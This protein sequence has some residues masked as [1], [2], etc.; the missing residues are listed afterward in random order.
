MSIFYSQSSCRLS[1]KAAE[2]Y[3]SVTN[4]Q[5]PIQTSSN[6]QHRPHPAPHHP[7]HDQNDPGRQ[8]LSITKPGV[9][10]L[11]HIMS[12]LF[13]CVM[14]ADC[15]RINL[16]H[17]QGAR[18]L[19]HN[20]P[21]SSPPRIRNKYNEWVMCL[22]GTGGEAENCTGVR[23]MADS[24]CPANWVSAVLCFCA[25]GSY[26]TFRAGGS[27]AYTNSSDACMRT[28]VLYPTELGR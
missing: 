20:T 10:L 24:I 13:T 28:Y 7:E 2:G 23:Q 27:R 1:P 3:D 16:K 4:L 11:V 9:S 8:A 19:F 21:S 14:T 5:I 25:L 18:I 26:I 6:N 22:K 15:A 12:D 17:A